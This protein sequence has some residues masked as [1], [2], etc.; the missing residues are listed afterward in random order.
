MALIDDSPR[1]ATAMCVDNT[2]L[3]CL[4]RNVFKELTNLYPEILH[5]LNRLL[6]E[7]LRQAQSG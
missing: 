1:S 7:R 2:T 4:S 5:A 6:A 3:L